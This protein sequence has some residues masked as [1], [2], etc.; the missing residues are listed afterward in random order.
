MDSIRFIPTTL[1]FSYEEVRDSNKK[2]FQEEYNLL[3][4]YNSDGIED[5][6]K[7]LQ[8]KGQMQDT[9]QVLL[10]LIVE[11]H[12]KVDRIESILKNENEQLL[13]L[14]HKSKIYA[15]HFDYIQAEKYTFLIDTIYYARISLP[16]FPKK[17]LP[18]YLIGIKDDIAKIHVINQKNADEWIAFVMSKEREEIR[19]IKRRNYDT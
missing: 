10:K 16:V 3:S 4:E 5:W 12:K 6:I 18:I 15:I 8:A 11:L 7:K 1:N 19:K 2:E 14:Q 17:E 13:P 9:D